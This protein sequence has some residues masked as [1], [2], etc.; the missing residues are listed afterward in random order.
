MIKEEKKTKAG[1]TVLQVEDPSSTC[2]TLSNHLDTYVMRLM[3]S[4]HIIA[5]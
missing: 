4:C 5:G 2:F 1:E 3:L